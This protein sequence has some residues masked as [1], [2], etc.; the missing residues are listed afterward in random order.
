[1]PLSMVEVLEVVEERSIISFQ[2]KS[3]L[4]E[5]AG[6]EKTDSDC[7]VGAEEESSVDIW[8]VIDNWQP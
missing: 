5:E 7:G 1:M 6:R 3:W 2:A 8:S 4:H